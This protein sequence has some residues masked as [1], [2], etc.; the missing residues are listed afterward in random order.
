MWVVLR[1]IQY[2]ERNGV[3]ETRHPGDWVDVSKQTANLWLARGDAVLPGQNGR[4]AAPIGAGAGVLV[5]NAESDLAW[6][7][8]RASLAPFEGEL[9]I[10]A[11]TRPWLAYRRTLIY[12]PAVVIRPDLVSVGFALLEKWDVVV[13]L[14]SYEQLACHVGDELEQ[15][16]TRAVVRDLRVPLYDTRLVFLRLCDETDRLI[17]LWQ[18]EVEDGANGAHAFLR[19]LY[20]VKPLVL[21]LP[22][23]WT[24]PHAR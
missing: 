1:S 13:P 7:A 5:V 18:D 20:T 9:E 10:E 17:T 11:V 21:A 15:D 2:I 3:S 12:D 6:A 22:I 16:K 19:A 4:K 24:D 23:T 14:A 8:A